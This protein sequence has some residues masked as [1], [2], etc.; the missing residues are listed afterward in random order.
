MIGGKTISAGCQFSR[1]S[2]FCPL[3]RNSAKENN[4]N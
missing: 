3:I 4:S 2:R 1:E